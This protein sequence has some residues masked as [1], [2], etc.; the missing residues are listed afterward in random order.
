MRRALVDKF[1]QLRERCP[2]WSDYVC[3]AVAILGENY[4]EGTINIHFD[5]LVDKGDYRRAEKVD[6]LNYLVQ[7]SLL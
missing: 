5:R 6:I 4:S 1:N 7:I 2:G 3:F